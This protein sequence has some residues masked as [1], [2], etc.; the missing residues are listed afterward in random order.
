MQM[1][2][3]IKSSGSLAFDTSIQLSF[4]FCY[5]PDEGINNIELLCS[6]H[7]N[8]D[9]VKHSKHNHIF[10]GESGYQNVWYSLIYPE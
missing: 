3:Y 5:E 8:F 7:S 4:N 1:S 9:Q 6:K 2:P 10:I